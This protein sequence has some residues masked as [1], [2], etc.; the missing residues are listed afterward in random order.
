MRRNYTHL[1]YEERVE[2]RVLRRQGISVRKVSK[3]ISRSPSTISRELKRNEQFQDTRVIYPIYAQMKA[4][5]RRKRSYRKPRLKSK[6]LQSY[7]EAKL[8]LGWSPETIAGRLK[9]QGKK[10]AERVSPEAIYQWVYSRRLDLR[11]CLVRH[12]KR[13]KKRGQRK[14]H[15]KPHIANRTPISERPVSVVDRKIPGHWESDAMLSSGTNNAL[16]VVIERTSRRVCLTALKNNT[17]R[18]T[19]NALV[20][21]LRRFPPELRK[22]ITYD[23]GSENFDHMVTNTQL[24]TNSYFCQPFHSWE[25]GSVENIIGVIRR[26]Y[27]KGT[28]LKTI[29]AGGLHLL[30][31]R[32]N[33]LPR[34]CLQ[35]STPMEV[36][37][38]QRVALQC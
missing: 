32:L 25:K 37:R 34:K 4:N 22:S 16:H 29:P 27:P 36:F 5:G 9:A 24:G 38:A 35:F 6:K 7:V 26:T 12:H 8:R 33:N 14:T 21:R 2:I 30:E 18:A 15:R 1:S 23:N 20:K 28:N 31:H 3:E 13:R 11:E 19:T 10:P 17:A